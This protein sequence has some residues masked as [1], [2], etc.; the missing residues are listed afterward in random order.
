MGLG[1]SG[2]PGR[3]ITTSP[4]GALTTPSAEDLLGLTRVLMGAVMEVGTETTS[5]GPSSIWMT[6]NSV[7]ASA[8]LHPDPTELGLQ[9]S[10]TL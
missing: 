7:V 4:L 8:E 9:Y 1:G 3:E 6:Q 10:N 5:E 2:V